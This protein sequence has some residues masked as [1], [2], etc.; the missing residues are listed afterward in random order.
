[1][2]PPVSI[3]PATAD[4][5]PVL[6]EVFSRAFVDDPMIRWPLG[7][8]AEP[9]DAIRATFAAIY[10]AVV[11]S[12]VVWEAGD[13]DGFAVWIPPGTAEDMFESDHAV[14]DELAA[15]TDD[16]G[17]RYDVLWSWIEARVPDDA[18]YL[19]VLGVDPV[20]QGEGVGT[21]LLRF[22]LDRARADGV[23]AFLET[24]V[25]ANVGYYE[26]FGFRVI[27][28]GR[29]GRRWPRTSGSCGPDVGSRHAV[30]VGER[31]HVLGVFVVVDP[32]FLGR[33]RRSARRPCP[34]APPRRGRW[35]GLPALRQ[36][37]LPM[38]SLPRPRRSRR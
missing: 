12:G 1:M 27:G 18:Y 37:R 13:G 33:P 31:L 17:R 35:P 22:G 34:G 8:A 6:A 3:A 5:L 7:P 30:E 16:G 25:E 26:R 32:R 10:R 14:R 4:R 38:T 19:D 29:A 36:P 24:A 28:E 20:R 15:L 2:S 23:D 21:A 11:G 9:A